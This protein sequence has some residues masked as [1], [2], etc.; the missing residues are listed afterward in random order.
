MSMRARHKNIPIFIPHMGC[1][2]RCV[3][4][5]QCAISGQNKFDISDVKSQIESAIATLPPDARAEIAYFGGSFTAID[6]PLMVELLDLAQSYVDAGRVSG[7]RCS[8]RPDALGDDIFE[9]LSRYAVTTIELGLQS[10]DDEVLRLCRRGHSA[11][12]A[13]EACRRVVSHGYT[14]GGQMMLGL[15]GSDAD[16]ELRTARE[17]CELGATEARVYPTVVFDSTALGEMLKAGNYTPLTDAEAAERC[18]PV[19]ALFEQYGV[20]LLRVGLCASEVLA[21]S[22]VLGGA[23]HPALGEM[24]YSALF[25]QRMST[26]LDGQTTTGRV[27]RFCVPYAKTSQALGQK[28]ANAQ[29]LMAR[30]ALADVCAHEDEALCGT[31]VTLTLI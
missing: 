29:A 20:Q 30:Y 5:D 4:C 26:R 2:H 6:R 9:I 28:R 19:L 14:L 27:A 10:M 3:F 17:I 21:S 11:E 1:P 23:N 8:T 13:R 12:E 31:Q 25:L 7:I 22:R 15:P 16:K 24:C 18:A